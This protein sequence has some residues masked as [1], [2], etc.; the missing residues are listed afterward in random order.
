MGR[1]ADRPAGDVLT[2]LPAARRGGFSTRGRRWGDGLST[3]G[4]GRSRNVDNRIDSG[5]RPVYRPDSA[6]LIWPAAED[7]AHEGPG[8]TRP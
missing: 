7:G 4:T 5:G 2:C 8:E 3:I 1:R 6:R